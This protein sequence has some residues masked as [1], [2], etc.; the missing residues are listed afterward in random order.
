VVEEVR[1]AYYLFQGE[2]EVVVATFLLAEIG[3]FWSTYD[4]TLHNIK[5]FLVS[6]ACAG[7]DRKMNVGA[8][9]FYRSLSKWHMILGG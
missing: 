8:R 1:T 9:T 3:C 2:N 5:S 6:V 4:T 7:S